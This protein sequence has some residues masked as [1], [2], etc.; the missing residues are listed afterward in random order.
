MATPK[1][2]FIMADYGHDPTETA[3]PFQ[4]FLKAGFDISFATEN[5]K[6]PECDKKMLEGITQKLLVSTDARLL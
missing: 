5:G 6:S 3:I 2:L 1:V 4:E